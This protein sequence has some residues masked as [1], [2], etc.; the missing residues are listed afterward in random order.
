MKNTD[1]TRIIIP[2]SQCTPGMILMQPIVDT[3]SGSTILGRDQLLT[4][5]VL[6]R[7]QKFKHTEIWVGIKP[8]ESLWQVEQEV[9]ASYREYAAIL[10][11]ILGNDTKEIQVKLGEVDALAKSITQEFTSNFNLLACVNLVEDMETDLYTHSINVAFLSLLIARW[12]NYNPAKLSN[13]LVA[14]LLHDVGKIDLPEYLIDKK[15]DFTIKE[16]IEFRRHP[17]YGYDKLCKYNELD[18]EVLKAVISHHERCDGSGYPLNLNEDRINDIA[19]IIGIADEYD[20]LKQSNHIFEIVK[21]LK[22][23]MLRKFDINMLLEFCNNVIN[24]YIGEEVVLNTGETA[25]VVFI[26]PHAL[27]RPIVKVKE[28]Y[29]DLY[30]NVQIGIEKVL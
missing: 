30:E 16:K 5:E 9:M 3:D 21:I 11:N 14:A 2:I 15:N 12:I 25:E 17:I 6:I 29:I 26:Q 28:K 10:K 20:N 8:G 18:N 7:I 24:Y 19:R 22:C 23:E 4:K 27:H 13:V 1:I